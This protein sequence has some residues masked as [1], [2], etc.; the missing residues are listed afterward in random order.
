MAEVA[1]IGHEVVLIS[2]LL[3]PSL[4][5]AE[6]TLSIGCAADSVGLADLKDEDGVASRHIEA[7]LSLNL[8][9][10]HCVVCHRH[11]PD[12]SLD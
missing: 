2:Q 12:K 6:I 5:S 10:C 7:Q 9:I 8:E 11:P 1:A 3:D 4:D